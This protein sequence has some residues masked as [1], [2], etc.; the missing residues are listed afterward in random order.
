[1]WNFDGLSSSVFSWYAAL[2]ICSTVFWANNSFFAKKLANEQ[3]TQKT[4]DLLIHSFFVSDLSDLL[5]VAHFWWATWA[6]CSHRS[7]LVSDLSDS[8]TSLTKKEGMSKLLIFLTNLAY[9][10][11]TKK[12]RFQ[13]FLANI[14]WA[15]R[16]FVLSDLSD[17]L[18][19]THLS[20][21][22]W[23]N[24]SQSLNWFERNE[25]M[26]KWAMSKWANSQPCWYLRRKCGILMASPAGAAKLCKPLNVSSK[27]RLERDLLII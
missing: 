23:V 1:M 21:V 13:I 15:N 5:M 19:V 27:R 8:L 17:L 20:W 7:F 24:R 25:W 18:T 14:F 2:G 11:H 10:K 3:F 12:I 4:S 22:I 9:I 26:S 16:S 6:I